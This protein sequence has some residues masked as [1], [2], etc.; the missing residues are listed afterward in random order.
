MGIQIF[1]T[2]LIYYV[3]YVL[4]LE[5]ILQQ[6]LRSSTTLTYGLDPKMIIYFIWIG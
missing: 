6:V 4:N 1:M 5:R 3:V 2:F